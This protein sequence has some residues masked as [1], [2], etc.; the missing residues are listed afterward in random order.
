MLLTKYIFP[1]RKTFALRTTQQVRNV[2]KQRAELRLMG[3]LLF[4]CIPALLLILVHY[5][6]I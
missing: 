4:G 6:A 5:Q 1:M 3:A 2:Q